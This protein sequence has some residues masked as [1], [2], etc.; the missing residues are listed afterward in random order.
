MHRFIGLLCCAV[1][2]GFVEGWRACIT[3][4]S[5]A[6]GDRVRA[7][8]TF[9]NAQYFDAAPSAASLI[10]ID[11]GSEG[12]V[13]KKDADGDILVKWKPDGRKRWALADHQELE[14]FRGAAWGAPQIPWPRIVGL[15]ESDARTDVEIKAQLDAVACV[16]ILCVEEGAHTYAAAFVEAGGIAP[17][18]E[19]LCSGAHF[20]CSKINSDAFLAIYGIVSASEAHRDSVLRNEAFREILLEKSYG[21]FNRNVPKQRDDAVALLLPILFHNVK[22]RLIEPFVL[23]LYNYLLYG[24]SEAEEKYLSNVCL[25]LAHFLTEKKTARRR[26]KILIQ[27]SDEIGSS[28]FPKFCNYLVSLLEHSSADI[29]KNVL[30]IIS[31]VVRYL[32][33]PTMNDELFFQQLTLTALQQMAIA[34]AA[35]NGIDNEMVESSYAWM[36]NEMETCEYDQLEISVDSLKNMCTNNG[37]LEMKDEDIGN[38]IGDEV[39]VP[40]DDPDSSLDDDYMFLGKRLILPTLLATLIVIALVAYLGKYQRWKRL[41]RWLRRRNPW[42]KA[43]SLKTKAIRKE[44][45]AAAKSAQRGREK[46]EAARLVAAAENKVK[47]K[48]AAEQH[49]REKKENERQQ[50][51][52]VAAAAARRA[53]EEQAQLTR[54]RLEVEKQRA[55]AIWKQETQYKRMLAEADRHVARCVAESNR[56]VKL[57]SGARF[58]ETVAAAAEEARPRMERKRWQASTIALRAARRSAAAAR[59]SDEEAVQ[60]VVVAKSRAGQQAAAARIEAEERS[61][62]EAKEAVAEAKKAAKAERQARE[63]ARQQAREAVR[64]HAEAVAAA[65]AAAERKR[66]AAAQQKRKAAEERKVAAREAARRQAEAA[67]AAERSRVAAVERARVDAAERERAAAVAAAAA[68]EQA[69]A[70]AAAERARVDAAERERAA[71]VAAAAAAEQAEAAAAAERARVDA[72]ERER[73]AAVAANRVAGDRA[74]AAAAAEQEARDALEFDDLF[75][76]FTS[77]VQEVA[78]EDDAEPEPT[79]PP[80]ELMCP[81]TSELM[82]DPVM[83]IDGNTYEREAIEAWFGRGKTTSPLTNEELAQTLLTP[84]RLV[85]KLCESWLERNG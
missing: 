3:F 35:S 1:A 82:R 76:L 22:L 80:D 50:R 26:V 71:A 16:A 44:S 28:M 4:N 20:P 61:V 46:R 21:L 42:K 74:A 73:A 38:V 37:W 8:K 69:E 83:T 6:I 34:Y 84:N 53:K 14:V 45:A 52:E 2:P 10:G 39:P 62:V 7:R 33:V 70:A 85:K 57:Y 55:R 41:T 72:A 75:E 65:A 25:A 15:L 56:V 19:L 29:Q 51:L 43:R 58:E 54:A 17:L 64:Q 68:V 78:D 12:V 5:I 36:D 66:V 24:Y 77:T 13:V 48:L 49:A 40:D 23:I 18:V 59:E 27:L 9:N 47:L 11:V 30:L 31:R 79:P 81:I 67:A 63:A 32:P 60:S